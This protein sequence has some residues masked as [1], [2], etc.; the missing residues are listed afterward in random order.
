MKKP[1]PLNEFDIIKTY[2][3]RPPKQSSVQQAVGDDCAI[4]SLDSNKQLVFSMDTL[5]SGRHFP[6]DASPYDIATRALCTSIS[7]LAAMGATPLWLTLG[8][9]L[10]EMNQAWLSAFSDGVYAIADQFE[11]DLIGGDTTKGPLTITVQVHGQVA[12][13]HSLRR[14]QAMEGDTVF[15]TGNL[16][17]GAAGL[18]VLENR[19]TLERPAQD[20]LHERF[21]A[22]TPQV[23]IGQRLI[24]L[25]HCA[26]DISDGLLGDAEHIAKASGVSIVF[27]IEK[28]PVSKYLKGVEQKKMWAWALSGGDDYQLLFTVNQTQLASVKHLMDTQQLEATAIGRVVSGRGQVSCCLHGQPYDLRHQP[29]GYQHFAS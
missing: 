1:M 29:T 12:H 8:L 13:G 28:L 15:V 6:V 18:A 22:P 27:D 23:K 4:V 17:D 25:A 19:L 11:M 20:Y 10:P 16:G 24:G 14:D 2:F 5:V 7:D 26:I 3:T 21:Y 9:T